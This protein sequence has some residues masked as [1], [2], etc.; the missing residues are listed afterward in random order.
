MGKDEEKSCYIWF[1]IVVCVL[2]FLGLIYH[3]LQI[4]V[5]KLPKSISIYSS[6]TLLFLWID[7]ILLTTVEAQLYTNQ[8][9]CAAYGKIH[10]IVWFCAEFF[11][12]Y[13]RIQALEA[14]L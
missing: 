1:G 10:L 12:W 14:A 4:K 9:Q 2:L 7:S 13:L 6:A 5:H 3:A 8:A 11:Y